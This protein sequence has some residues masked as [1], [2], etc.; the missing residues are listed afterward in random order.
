LISEGRVAVNGVVMREPGGKLDP[1][2]DTVMVDGVEVRPAATVH[3][4]FNKPIGVVCS[5]ADGERRRRVIDLLPELTGRVYTVGRLDSDSRGLIFVTNDGDFAQR[6]AHPRHQID[7]TYEVVVKGRAAAESLERLRGGVPIGDGQT[8]RAEARALEATSE[9]TRLEI[10]LREGMNREVRRMLAR[11]GL[12]VIE[13]VRTRIGSVVLGNL[14]EG[15]SR[16][17]SAE[18]VRTLIS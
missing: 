11:V 3:L 5:N 6:V 15:C 1:D 14:R 7:K 9:R 13:L 10:T 4:A 2:S 17:L 16:N 18:E 8:A 12:P